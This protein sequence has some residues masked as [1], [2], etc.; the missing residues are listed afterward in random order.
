MSFFDEADEPPRAPRAEPRR[1]RPS[2][3]GRPPG[4]QQAIQTRRTVAVVAVIV[5][6]VLLALLVH[7]CDVSATNSAL[8]NYTISVN[9]LI[10]RSDATGTRLFSELTSGTGSSNPT[11]LQTQIDNTL[12]DART[13]FTQTQALSVP[14]AMQSA[15]NNLLLAMKMRRDGVAVIA[16]EIQPALGTT[17]NADAVSQIVLAMARFFG[18]DVVYKAYTGPD[19]ASALHS[20]GIAVGGSS[21]EPINSGQ[22]LPDLSWLQKTF[23]ASKLG[24]KLPSSQVNTAAPG[25]HGHSLNSVSVGGTTLSPTSTNTIQASPAPT[26]TLSLTNGGQFTEYD[27]GCKVSISGLSDTGTG[28]VSQTTPGQTTTCSVTLPSA[29]TAGTYQVT[30]EVVPVPGEKNTANNSMTFSVSFQ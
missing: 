4:D 30:A 27:V 20:A 6:I 15:Q 1:R 9:S 14:G 8:K 5:V 3:R 21:G 13:E 22:F 19:I 17:A 29:P 25:L 16:N 28:T 24:A 18:S 11:G 7:S 23:I 10:Q 12:D 2:G 26:F